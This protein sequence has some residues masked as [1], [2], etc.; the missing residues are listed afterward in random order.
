VV[1]ID[2]IEFTEEAPAGTVAVAEDEF[3]VMVESS[4]LHE[5]VAAPE[6]EIEDRFGADLEHEPSVPAPQIAA[7][8]AEPEDSFAGVM[9]DDEE[10]T[11]GPPPEPTQS[12]AEVENFD[13]SSFND[14]GEEHTS[15]AQPAF[16]E[17]VPLLRVAPQEPA[18]VVEEE[19]APTPA[20]APEPP[21]AVGI[22]DELDE[23]DFYLQQGMLDEARESLEVLLARH[24]DHPLVLSK[25]R[26]VEDAARSVAAAGGDAT[27]VH[28]G[29][30]RGDDLGALLAEAAAEPTTVGAQPVG[31]GDD[32]FET[33]YELG[34]ACKEMGLLDQAIAEFRLAM[35]DPAREVQC[36]HMIGMCLLSK[37][38]TQ[39][40]IAVFKQGLYAEGLVED[41]E[42]ALYYE[43]GL[44]YEQIGDGGEARYYLE[45]IFKRKPRYRD[46]ER[47]LKSLNAMAPGDAV[48]APVNVVRK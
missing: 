24:P 1:D 28:D 40:A 9:A 45:R 12:E 21:V 26:E 25:L 33:H 4:G 36:D 32:D 3:H 30:A 18:A 29:A 13:F 39:D 19:P 10:T 16:E 42:L 47:R 8:A 37:G 22:E 46:V 6:E 31:V 41:E 17:P 7:P 48:A 44:V 14:P 43:L 38:Q 11:Y 27:V 20:S 23:A 35:R 2:E 34:I 15:A 5:A